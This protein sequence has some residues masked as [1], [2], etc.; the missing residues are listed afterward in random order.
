MWK[1]FAAVIFCV[2]LVSAS[3]PTACQC[4]PDVPVCAAGVALML[5]SCGCCKVCARQLNEDCSRTRPCDSAKGLECNFGG[6][7]DAAQGICRA[8]L[9]GRSCEFNSRIYQ[10]GETF[11]TNCKYRCTCTDGYIRCA[12]LCNRD[13]S[14]YEVGCAKWKKVKAKGK[15]CER[16]ICLK[17][18]NTGRS[19]TRKHRQK[20]NNDASEKDF[21]KIYE[22]GYVRRGELRASRNHTKRSKSAKVSQCKLQ[23]TAWSPCS[24]SCGPGIS[25]R[26]TNNNTECKLVTETQT[27]EIHSCKKTPNKE[28]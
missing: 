23:T 7:S 9:D 28:C 24:K 18:A 16:L 15:C 8:K 21:S 3:C 13:L 22:R 4:P 27:C 20:Y 25:S 6:G 26:M 14:M 10:N 1:F 5:D 17:D 19:L 11:Q 12:S 2:T